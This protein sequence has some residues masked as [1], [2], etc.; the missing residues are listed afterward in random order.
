M[1][2]V[3]RE[4]LYEGQ[5]LATAGPLASARTVGDLLKPA[6]E[7]HYKLRLHALHQGRQQLVHDRLTSENDNDNDNDNIEF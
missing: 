5:H 6:D 4:T 7:V 2:L 3:R 1:A